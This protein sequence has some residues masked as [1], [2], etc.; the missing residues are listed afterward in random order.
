MFGLAREKVRVVAPF[1]GG[2]F[3]G[4]VGLWTNIA[5]CIAAAKL[6]K[7]PVKLALSREGVFRV[8]GGRTVSEQYVAL[9][10]SQDGKL[11]GLTHT[12]LTATTKSGR[13]AEQC[14]FPARH[15]YAS[16]SFLI[17][18]KIVYLDTVAN[19]WMRAPGESIGTFAL[20]SAI[21]EL[22]LPG[23]QHLDPGLWEHSPHH[24]PLQLPA[25]SVDVA[26]A[27]TADVGLDAGGEQL[28]LKGC[29]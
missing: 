15:L 24:R 29:D 25:G 11:T 10:A 27:G 8:I 7:R 20:E 22:A 26:A 9:S 2:G 28:L 6:V 5:L 1:V 4:K 16:P 17:G 18:Q 19:T 21:D 12:G 3:G 13:Y 14:T 23:A